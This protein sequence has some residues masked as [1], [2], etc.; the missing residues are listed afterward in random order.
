[1]GLQRLIKIADGRRLS[2]YTVETLITSLAPYEFALVQLDDIKFIKDFI[3]D[4]PPHIEV[5]DDVRFLQDLNSR[6]L[7]RFMLPCPVCRQEQ[8]Y[9]FTTIYNPRKVEMLPNG[10]VNSGVV[11]RRMIT[12]LNNQTIYA[13]Q[14]YDNVFD[15]V[16]PSFSMFSSALCDI[17]DDEKTF[18][19]SGV[20]W[21]AF[22]QR[23]VSVCRRGLLDALGEFRID[24]NCGYNQ[25]HRLFA[26]FRLFDPIE[27][28]D[29]NEFEII[30]EDNENNREI[31]DAFEKLQNCLVLQ[32]TGQYPSLADMNM[33]E[34][35]KYYKVLNKE[36]Y[37]ELRT[38][39]FLHADGIGCGS[40][41]YLRR[42]FEHLI[43]E[44]AGECGLKEEIKHLHTNEVIT[45]IEDT[46]KT[47]I[48]K[49][50]QDVRDSIYGMMSLGVHLW[51][52]QK[53]QELFPY[54][55]FCIEQILDE[56]IRQKEYNAK[57]KKV[58]S[59]IAETQAKNK[60]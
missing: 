24:F 20:E 12:N 59:K 58:K 42:V 56:R 37:A 8:P 6:K 26:S 39:I 57:L 40:F 38:A 32:K 7:Q 11:G 3:A 36:K 51:S 10:N 19:S 60:K 53:C 34:V 55:Q 43:G 1:M 15:R 41:V 27:D 35:G 25:E 17:S 46:G 22:V 31:I 54:V 9:S 52:D 4:I 28:D 14:K 48:P 16:Q 47:I 23:S 29:K 21:D 44:I 18:I 2:E 5:G 50:L 45:A 49:D 33:F 13:G 30:S